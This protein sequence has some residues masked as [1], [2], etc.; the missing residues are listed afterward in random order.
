MPTP[1]PEKVQ[2][3]STA[4]EQLAREGAVDHVKKLC[5]QLSGYAYNTR[6]HMPANMDFTDFTDALDKV[7]KFCDARPDWALGAVEPLIDNA[8]EIRRNVASMLREI[9]EKL[10]R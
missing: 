10:E 4:A 5:A 9:V 3:P 8:S 1:P 2:K 6:S 7:V